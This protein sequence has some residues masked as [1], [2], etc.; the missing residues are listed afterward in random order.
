MKSLL[1]F[2]IYYLFYGLTINLLFVSQNLFLF[3]KYF[4]NPLSISR[5][6]YLFRKFIINSLTNYFSYSRIFYLLR[7]NINNSLSSPRIHYKFT[8]YFASSL[9]ISRIYQ[10]FGMRCLIWPWFDDF[11]PSLTSWWPD[12]TSN[13]LKFEFP[14]KF[15]VET[16]VYRIY[17][18]LLAQFDP[19]LM[20]LT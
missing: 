15:R 10:E 5:I 2:R 6:H 16:C 18:D 7:E 13:N 4:I 20:I 12:L 19:Y 9:S 1:F 14:A 17:F 11:D 8:S 3:R